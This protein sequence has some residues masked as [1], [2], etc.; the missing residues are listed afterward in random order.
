MG[1]FSIDA[2]NLCWIN[3]VE[4]NP[5]DLCL[6]GHAVAYIGSSVLEYDATVSATALYLLKSITEDHI[7]HKDNQ[8]L[9]CCGFFYIPND[10]LDEIHISGCTNG[11]DWTILHD[12]EDIVLILE[13][14]VEC[15]IPLEEYREEVFR[16]ADKIEAFY[17]KCTPKIVTGDD[18]DRNGYIAFWNEWHRRRNGI[19]ENS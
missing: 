8:I 10:R 7:I 18:F 12:N 4:D 17:A 16:F 1:R 19:N 5:E 11:I 6:H 3:G 13:D 14:G 2:I 9:P 15:H